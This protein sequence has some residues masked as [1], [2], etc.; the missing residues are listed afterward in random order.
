MKLWNKVRRAFITLQLLSQ[1]R[2]AQVKDLVLGPKQNHLIEPCTVW[3]QITD[4][5]NRIVVY[6]MVYYW[7]GRRFSPMRRMF[8]KGVE[9]DG[10]GIVPFNTIE[11]YLNTFQHLDVMYSQSLRMLEVSVSKIVVGSMQA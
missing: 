11:S 1:Y 3:S 8:G 4:H 10:K 2:L 5:H 9:I 6:R 7:H